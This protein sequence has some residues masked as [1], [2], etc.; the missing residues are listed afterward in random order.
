MNVADASETSRWV[1]SPAGCSRISRSKPI[2]P[3]SST[4]VPRRRD[5]SRSVMGM[6]R[7]PGE[8][9]LENGIRARSTS[10]PPLPIPPFARGGKEK[11]ASI[12]RRKRKKAM[13][14][15]FPPLAKGGIGGVVECLDIPT[16]LESYPSAT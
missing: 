1:L 7:P 3:P 10:P 15:Q 13:A 11:G 4:E 12:E 14:G 16:A 2:A 6:S 5:S 8:E 9:V